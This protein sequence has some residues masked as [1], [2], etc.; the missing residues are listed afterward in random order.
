MWA[1]FDLADDGSSFVDDEASTDRGVSVGYLGARAMYELGLPLSDMQKARL[2]LMETM[3]VTNLNG[4][5]EASTGTW[6]WNGL[7]SPIK[8]AYDEYAVIQYRNLFD[9]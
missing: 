5:L 9:N 2:K 6:Y 8:D 3:P 7:D 4:Y 1:N